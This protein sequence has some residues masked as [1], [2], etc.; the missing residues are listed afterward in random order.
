MLGLDPA[1]DRADLKKRI[2]IVLQ[3]T[4]VDRYLTVRE[5][6]AMYAAYYPDPRPV[7]EVIEL[8]GLAEKRAARVVKLS[9][10]QQRRLDVAIALAGN[11]DLL[12]L[13]E[14]TT[15][16][17]P[18]ARHEAWQLVKD[19]AD[20]GKTVL[21]TTH[22]M[23]EAQFL[24][25]RVAVMARGRIVAEG[26]PDTIGGRDVARATLRFRH[27]PGIDPPAGLGITVTVD[28]HLE[29]TPDD[30]AVT[31][32]N[33]TGWAIEHG[34][35]LDDLQISRPSLEDVYLRAHR[36]PSWGGV[37]TAAALTFFQLRYV[38][39][40][41]WR[42]PASAFFTF[43]FPLMFLVIFTSLLGHGTV[44]LGGHL[45]HQSTYY[46]AE[47]AAFSVITACYN[48]IAISLT[49]QRDTG[50]LKRTNGTPLPASCLLQRAC[51]ACPPDVR[52]ARR[53]HGAVRSPSSTTPTFRPARQCS[54]S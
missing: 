40:A 37:M 53:A 26:T 3:S 34:I 45:V 7:D 10:G 33:L 21:L 27:V 16:F 11:P 13:D 17:D 51:A 43:A 22:Y 12:F 19:L 29:I 36:R 23:D 1:R 2:G 18:S 38:N 42:N 41:F 39:K 14:P 47:M 5:T 35:G 48:N 9:G 15:G 50:V 54:A 30:L 49:F 44:V 31:L 32:H 20:L 46:V 52:A 25:D 8:V 6:V 4:G 28:G 24:A